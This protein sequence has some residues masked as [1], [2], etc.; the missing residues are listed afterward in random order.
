MLYLISCVSLFM[1][2]SHAILPSI[3]PS[4]ACDMFFILRKPYACYHRNTFT[5]HEHRHFIS[6]FVVVYL[7]DMFIPNPLITHHSMHMPCIL[8]MFH[9]EPYSHHLGP[10]PYD[11]CIFT[12]FTSICYAPDIGSTTPSHY[13]LMLHNGCPH[14][15]LYMGTLHVFSPYESQ[16][17]SMCA[18]Y[19]IDNTHAMHKSLFPLHLSKQLGDI[20]LGQH[21]VDKNGTTPSATYP[22]LSHFHG[23]V[24]L[25]PWEDL[26][27]G[28]G[29]DDAEHPTD[30][31]MDMDPPP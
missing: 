8:A 23:D 31:T 7:D 11:I 28:G 18:L 29:G 12:I 9:S 3:A 14:S 13:D 4:C 26:P 20:Y 30:I 21:V 16:A 10:S 2:T 15:T 27:Q 24:V 25:D 1:F 19:Y 6:K 5:I 17:T 22:V